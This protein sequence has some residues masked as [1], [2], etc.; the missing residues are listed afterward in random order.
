MSV[1][2]INGGEVYHVFGTD[3]NLEADEANIDLGLYATYTKA[4]NVVMGYY[5]QCGITED[6]VAINNDGENLNVDF[7]AGGVSF[8]ID[9]VKVN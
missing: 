4:L 6:E 7:E 2:D 1:D 9:W 5:E 3:S 8:W